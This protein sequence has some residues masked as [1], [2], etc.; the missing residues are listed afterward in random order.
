QETL[1]IYT[2]DG[3]RG[4]KGYP[5]ALLRQSS[6][7]A[8]VHTCGPLPLMKAAEHIC[9]ERGMESWHSLEERMACGAGACLGCVVRTVS[10]NKL[11][12]K[13]GPVFPGEELP[14]QK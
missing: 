8:A 12:C 4:L 14:W 2:E 9:R 6:P 1:F 10:G 13:D 3:S 7:Q 11:V 5:T